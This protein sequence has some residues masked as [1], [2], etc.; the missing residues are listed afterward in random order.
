MSD[1]KSAS[2]V[3]TP[4]APK[5][6]RGRK[7]YPRF[8]VTVP[9]VASSVEITVGSPDAVGA[10]RRAAVIHGRGR[11]P[12]PVLAYDFPNASAEQVEG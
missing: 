9:I 12:K 6:K 8:K 1:E 11:A 7:P 5:A 3:E 10:V 4:E 2:Q